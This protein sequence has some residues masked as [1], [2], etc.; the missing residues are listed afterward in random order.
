VKSIAIGERAVDVA[1]KAR[2]PADAR[3]RD[4]RQPRR[5]ARRRRRAAAGVR[6]VRRAPAVDGRRSRCCRAATTG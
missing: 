5:R 1:A 3:G 6:P 4:R 2:H